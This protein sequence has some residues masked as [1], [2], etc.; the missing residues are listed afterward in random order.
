MSFP[1]L[2]SWKYGLSHCPKLLAD[3][4]HGEGLFPLGVD[5]SHSSTQE[6]AH[7]ENEKRRRGQQQEQEEDTENEE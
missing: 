4:C 2:C 6:D 5:R 1:G 3:S 7:I